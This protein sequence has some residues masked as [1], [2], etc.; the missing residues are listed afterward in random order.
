LLLLVLR[1]C[2]TR[3]VGGV[4]LPPLKKPMI[5]SQSVCLT[6]AL[7]VDDFGR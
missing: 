1:G 6:G 3:A 2:S 5:F 7:G 4:P